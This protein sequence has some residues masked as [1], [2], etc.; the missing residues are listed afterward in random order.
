MF[1]RINK[2]IIK[3][4][5]F[6]LLCYAYI[7]IKEIIMIYDE[8]KRA[9]I[10]AIKEKDIVARSIYSVLLNKFMLENIKKREQHLELT[11]VDAVQILQK[12]IK[13][14][15]DELENYKKVNNN[16]EVNNISKQV[17]I[18]NKY[19]PKM[20]DREEIRNIILQLDDKSIPNVMKHFKTNYAGKCDMRLVQEVL[21]NI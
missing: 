2:F 1:L 17:E 6:F 20:M 12:T 4:V 10:I 15:S 16:E 11:D 9:N 8:I 21:K 3:V 7:D 13:E 19:L 14:L 18:V 5:L